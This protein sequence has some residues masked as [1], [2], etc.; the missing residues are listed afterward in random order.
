MD[1]VG[2]RPQMMSSVGLQSRGHVKAIYLE[3]VDATLTS[4][5]LTQILH[6][7]VHWNTFVC[8]CQNHCVKFKLFRIV[9]KVKLFNLLNMTDWM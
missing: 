1:G 5:P 3:G 7:N 2:D 6:A 8:K 4:C 9:D